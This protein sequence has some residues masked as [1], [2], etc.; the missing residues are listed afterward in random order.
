MFRHTLALAVVCQLLVGSNVQA[1]NSVPDFAKS[2]PK[3][4]DYPKQSVDCAVASAKAV[5]QSDETLVGAWIDEKHPAGLVVITKTKTGYSHIHAYFQGG[6]SRTYAKSEEPLVLATSSDKLRRWET[7]G[8]KKKIERHM[9]TDVPVYF[10]ASGEQ[11]D[12]YRFV[13]QA[14]GTL[15]CFEFLSYEFSKGQPK[16]W[17]RGRPFKLDG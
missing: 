9:G 6:S 8:V 13:E 12:V 16:P 17:M 2:Y 14:D 5:L 4:C 1:Q 15:L 7:S 10:N 11:I 3:E